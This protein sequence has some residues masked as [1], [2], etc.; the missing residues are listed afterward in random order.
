MQTHILKFGSHSVTL[1]M[2]EPAQVRANWLDHAGAVSA[3]PYW[4]RVWPAARVLCGFLA[5]EPRWYRQRRVFEIGAG[6]GLPSLLCACEAASVCCTD[7]SPEAGPYLLASVAANGFEHV[8]VKLFDWSIDTNYPEAELL[9]MADIGYETSSLD[10]LM[11][12]IS[13]YQGAADI[14]VAVP[15]RLASRAFAGLIQ[16]FARAHYRF[17][18]TEEGTET[19]VSLYVL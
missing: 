6:M 8:E 14:L 1:C 15:E 7:Q 4:A 13:H 12:C 17:S 3:A 5:D 18:D 11:R 9:L 2:P 19:F 10:G 16:P